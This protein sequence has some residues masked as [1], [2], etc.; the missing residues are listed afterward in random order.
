MKQAKRVI[1][2]AA[3][4]IAL[5]TVP[6][7]S[8][9]K[10]SSAATQGFDGTVSAT[11]HMDGTSPGSAKGVGSARQRVIG[12]IPGSTSSR[13]SKKP[14]I[15]SGLRASEA[16]LGSGTSFWM[17]VLKDSRR[18]QEASHWWMYPPPETVER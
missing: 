8:F 18:V 10:G 12:T 16:S 5:L 13:P 14:V 9:A 17:T 15:C 2:V 6:A 3:A 11:P 4:A 1:L 7:T